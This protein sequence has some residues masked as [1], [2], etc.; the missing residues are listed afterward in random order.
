MSKK[1]I[2][3][4]NANAQT[5]KKE[6]KGV[7]LLPSIIVVNLAVI[8]VAVLTIFTVK[9]NMDMDGVQK[10]SAF[11]RPTEST[12]SDYLESGEGVTMP[13]EYNTEIAI[14]ST[15]TTT[16]GHN[17]VTPTDK[18]YAPSPEVETYT[19]IYETKAT[20]T[21]QTTTTRIYTTHDN[22]TY[23][24]TTYTQ[25][26]MTMTT[27]SYKATSTSAPVSVA[28]TRNTEVIN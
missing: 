17:V 1:K 15:A 25:P 28:P 26:D 10:V 6:G 7:A 5:Q 11:D 9:D 23:P 22:R 20:I 8:V 16:K 2:E 24:Q 14:E 27:P 12:L 21:H 18:P 4:E 19:H 13:V 3:N